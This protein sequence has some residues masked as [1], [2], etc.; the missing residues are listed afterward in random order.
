MQLS[1]EQK[2]IIK[3]V[4]KGLSNIEIA[5][6]MGYSPDTIKKR[7]WLIYKLFNVRGRIELVNKLLK[8]KQENRT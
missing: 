6:K 4:K 8:Y 7:L 3:C 2:T 1:E 5:E